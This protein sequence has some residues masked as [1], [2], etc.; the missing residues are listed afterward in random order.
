[1]PSSGVLV[2]FSGGG[3]DLKAQEDAQLT[4]RQT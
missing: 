3:I 1:V 4:A 2:G